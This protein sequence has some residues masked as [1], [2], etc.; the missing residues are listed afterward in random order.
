MMKQIDRIIIAVGATL[1]IVLIA[2]QS[3]QLVGMRQRV[4]S[5]AVEVNDFAAKASA[6]EKP[7]PLQN[8]RQWSERVLNAYA[9]MPVASPRTLDVADFYPPATPK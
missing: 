9:T 3:Y 2:W 6:N 7:A 5:K 8:S 1:L 4:Q